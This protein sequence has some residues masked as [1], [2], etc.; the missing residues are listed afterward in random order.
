MNFFTIL[1]SNYWTFGSTGIGTENETVL[2]CQDMHRYGLS[3]SDHLLDCTLNKT[4]AMVV[5]VDVALGNLI[6]LLSMTL[7]LRW[8]VIGRLSTRPMRMGSYL[9]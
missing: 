4:P 7:F 9:A 2:T 3:L 1:V 6:P 8:M 5:P